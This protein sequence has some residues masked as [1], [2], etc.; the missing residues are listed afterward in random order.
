MLYALLLVMVFEEKL[1]TN[2]YSKFTET[3]LLVMDSK[4]NK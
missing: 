1:V 2:I 3:E 4:V